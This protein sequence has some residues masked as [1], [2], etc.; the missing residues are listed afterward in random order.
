MRYAIYFAA[1]ADDQLMQLG[2]SW[3]GRDPFSG[4]GLT[5][6]ALSG[7]NAESFRD[8][9]SSPRR[10]GFHGTLKAPFSRH[11]DTDEAALIRACEEL[12]RTI[13]PYEIQGL[14]VNRL[15]KFLA[16]TPDQQE[17]SL[18]AFAALCVRHFERYRAPLSDAD[19]ARRRQS[20][21]TPKQDAYVA[22]WGY[23]YVFDE[24]RFHMTLSNKLDDERQADLLAAAA[25]SHFETVTG[26]PRI[27]R[28]FALYT[29]PER[30]APF[31]VHTVFDLTGD[32]PPLEAGI[33]DDRLTP[34]ETA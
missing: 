27:C 21:L 8:L 17:P 19:L 11:R 1:A 10:Y 6:P 18:S 22:E 7:L 5:Q 28:T 30:G 32:I 14:S 31:D 9:T 34:K 2:N 3:L 15:G 29:E 13:A 16:L 33:S 20:N 12:A 24:F 26:R 4:D 25:R 23:P